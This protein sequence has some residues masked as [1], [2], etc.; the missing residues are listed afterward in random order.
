MTVASID[1]GTNTI[2]LLIVGIDIRKKIINTM[3]NEYRIPRIGKGLNP[4]KE[5]LVP[6]IEAMYYVWKEYHKI[7]L[8]YHCEKVLVTS[9]SAFRISSNGPELASEIKS[10]F[11]FDV[12]I[13]SGEEEAKYSYLGATF[14]FTGEKNNLI[15][16]IGGGSTELVFGKGEKILF[17]KSYLIGVV[18]GT[19]Y[20]LKH[21]PPLQKELNKFDQEI[22]NKFAEISFKQF[23]VD[24]AIAIAGTPTTLA[25]IKQNLVSYDESLIEGSTL[26]IEDI[27]NLFAEISKTSSKDILAKYKTVVKGREDVLLAGTFILQ[28][29]MKFLKLNSVIVSTKGIRYGA[30]VNFLLSSK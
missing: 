28:R 14:N 11:N 27:T 29:L 16:D 8:K 4:G 7:I 2:L 20:F 26:T 17:N 12:N 23:K 1:I 24:S 15:I 6:Q 3:L 5:I 19:E 21:D 22:S 30:V 25:C 9:T 13:I 18:S 10:R